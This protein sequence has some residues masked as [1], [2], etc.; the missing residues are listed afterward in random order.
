MKIDFSQVITDLHGNGMK[1]QY[2]TADD[3]I[4]VRDM[5]LNNALV[6]ALSFENRES[7]LS[8]TE[9]VRRFELAT[10]IVKGGEIEIDLD[11]AKLLQEAANEVYGV[12]IYGRIKEILNG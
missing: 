7:K 8:E 1:E 5:T 6:G 11:D 3:K 9:K 10:R 4:A 12:V 2:P